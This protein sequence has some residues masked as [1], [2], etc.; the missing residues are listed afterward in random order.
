M[1]FQS[2]S[3]TV[4]PFSVVCLLGAISLEGMEFVLSKLEAHFMA[5]RRHS[6]LSFCIPLPFTAHLSLVSAQEMS[7]K[8]AIA[9]G[10]E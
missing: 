10:G 9:S 4:S 3:Q 8:L 7:V 6:H 5:P 1:S 2:V